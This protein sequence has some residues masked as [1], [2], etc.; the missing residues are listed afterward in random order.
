MTGNAFAALGNEHRVEILRTLVV[1]VENQRTGLPFTELYDRTGIDSSSQFSYHLDR[2][3]TEFVREADGE[4]VPTSAGERVVRAIRSGIYTEAPS[5]EP[6]TVEGVCPECASTTLRAAYD[7]PHLRV[8]CTDCDATVVTYDLSPAET[9]GRGPFETLAACNRRALR[10]YETAI[11]GSCPTC[12][13][14][15]TVAIETGPDGDYA[16]VADCSQCGLRLFAPVE[17]PLFG[18][19]AVISFYWDRGVDVTDLRLWRLPAFIGDVDRRVLETEPLA[20]AL[21][22]HHGD[23]SIT[24]RIDA[25]GTVSVPD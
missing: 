23:A 18:H 13:G 10:E 4:Y 17:L 15:T 20:F 5:F 2:L 12:N 16:C 6:V 21:T 7:D 9:E 22:L 1:A 8:A 25:D 11:A 3:T 19:P 24:A 14:A